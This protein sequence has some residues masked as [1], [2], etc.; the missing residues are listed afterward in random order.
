MRLIIESK[1]TKV[2][3]NDFF[4]KFVLLLDLEV[5]KEVLLKNYYKRNK[6]S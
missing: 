5:G 2:I 3:F 4:N 6:N 1:I